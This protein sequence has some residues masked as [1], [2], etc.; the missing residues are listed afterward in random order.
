MKVAFWIIDTFIF[1]DIAALLRYLPIKVFTVI[2]G[3]EQKTVYILRKKVTDGC[4]LRRID[5]W[6]ISEIFVVQSNQLI[7]VFVT[8]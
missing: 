3:L 5:F 1:I 7:V 6:N 2:P 8:Q 4:V